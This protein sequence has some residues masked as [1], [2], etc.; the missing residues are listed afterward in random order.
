LELGKAYCLLGDFPKAVGAYRRYVDLR[1]K[2]PLGHLNAGNALLAACQSD[3]SSVLAASNTTC[4]TPQYINTVSNEFSLAGVGADQFLRQANASFDAGEFRLADLFF[5]GAGLTNSDLSAEGRFSWRLARLVDG[6]SNNE[7]ADPTIKVY[8]ISDQIQIN[9]RDQTWTNGTPVGGSSVEGSGAATLFW[10]GAIFAPVNV[11]QAGQYRLTV[12]VKNSPPPPIR[13][14]VERNFSSQAVLEF[15][16]GDSSWQELGTD[17]LLSS[18]IQL[19]GIRFLNDEVVN[20]VDRN[21]VI[22]WIRVER[23]N[24]EQPQ[25]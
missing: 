23:I 7:K 11:A 19:I 21:A 16:R 14:Q 10:N 17:I 3:S 2:N 4:G 18:G 1:P 5:S 6:M 13:I 22:D 24:D 8:L 15:T 9:A 25:K 20:G 12:K